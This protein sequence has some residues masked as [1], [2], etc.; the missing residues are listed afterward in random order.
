[1]RVYFLFRT[2]SGRVTKYK[3][4]APTTQLCSHQLQIKH[5]TKPRCSKS[6]QHAAYC[7]SYLGFVTSGGTHIPDFVTSG[8]ESKSTQNVR[9]E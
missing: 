9:D 8:G 4:H 6:I 7:E 5:H 2:A 3:D 1:M